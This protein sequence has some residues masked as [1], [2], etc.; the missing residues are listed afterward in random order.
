MAIINPSSVL[1]AAISI[2]DL[3]DS[4]GSD[5]VGIFDANTFEQVFKEARPLRADVRETSIIMKH[6]IENGTMVA[7]NHIIN[8]IQITLPLFIQ[9]I[10]YSSIYAQIRQAFIT[11]TKFTIQTRTG[12]YRNMYISEMP[13]SEESDVAS[14]IILGV[15]FEEAIVIFPNTTGTQP[16]NFSPAQPEYQSTV[17]IGQKYAIPISIAGGVLVQSFLRRL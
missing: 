3:L 15:K 9:S 4:P 14:A 8:P 2:V 17:L 13:H 10:F 5:T 12:V 1:S 16:S 11:A 7:D 6:P